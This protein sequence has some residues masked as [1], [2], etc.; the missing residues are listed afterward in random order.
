MAPSHNNGCV[1]NG[2]EPAVYINGSGVKKSLAGEKTWSYVT[3]KRLLFLLVAFTSV[4]QYYLSLPFYFFPIIL[5]LLFV[6]IFVSNLAVNN[7]F[8]CLWER[9]QQESKINK[10]IKFN[11][12]ETKKKFENKFIPM[13]DLYELYADEKIDFIDDVL[14]TLERRNEFVSYKLQWWHLKFFVMK[15]LPEMLKHDKAQDEEQVVEHYDRGNDFYNAF[16]GPMMVYTSGI[17][18]NETETLEEIQ[19]NKIKDVCEKIQL[20]EGERHLDIGCGWGTLV[21][22]AAENYGSKSTGVTLAQNQVEWALNKAKGKEILDKV[23]YLTMD[24]REIPNEKY[25]KITCLEMAEHVGIRLFPTFLEQVSEMLED[26]GIFY[27]QIAGI[28]R[29]WQWEDMLWGFF[30]DTYIF[31]GADASL[32]LLFSVGQLEAAGFEVESVKTIGIHYSDTI[33]NWYHNWIRPEVKIEMVKKYGIRL[34]NVWAIFLSWST[35]IAKQGNSTCYQ[36]VAH[37]N[38]NHYPRRRFIQNNKTKSE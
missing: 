29:A 12:E 3:F 1:K 2:V 6:P 8:Y 35:I 11:D 14:Q 34:Y 19:E 9:Y 30:M 5:L 24:Y 10:Y 20:K 21:N 27:L 18:Y 33:K 36:I 22:Y 23:N 38:F 4:T 37:K 25:D 26:D 32:P 15:F 17:R 16:L 13:R 28:R 31:P 7:V